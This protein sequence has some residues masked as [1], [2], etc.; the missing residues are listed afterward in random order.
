M[1]VYMI[2]LMLCTI[3]YKKSN[4]TKEKWIESLKFINRFQNYLKWFLTLKIKT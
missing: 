2:Q 4:G 3:K 1:Y